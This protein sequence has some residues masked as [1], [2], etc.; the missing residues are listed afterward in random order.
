MKYTYFFKNEDELNELIKNNS[1]KFLIEIADLKNCNFVVFSDK[2]LEADI[3]ENNSKKISILESEN[4]VLRE[5]LQAVLRG[6]MQ[7]LAYALY[8][9]DFNM[10]L[11]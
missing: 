5:G 7:S 4:S 2:E 11:K 8:P 1:D 6:D 9:E 10:N 3:E